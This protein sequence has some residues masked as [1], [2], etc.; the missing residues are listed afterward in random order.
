[1]QNI[2]HT[3]DNH[4]SQHTFSTAIVLT[5]SDLIMVSCSMKQCKS[6]DSQ[7]IV[8]QVHISMLVQFKSAAV[9]ITQKTGLFFF[10]FRLNHDL[11][12]GVGICDSIAPAPL[13]SFSSKDLGHFLWQSEHLFASV[14]SFVGFVV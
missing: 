7:L 5:W 4:I 12:I 3:C 8:S 14:P 2:T 1:M 11:Y 9:K 10:Q 13:I 6:S